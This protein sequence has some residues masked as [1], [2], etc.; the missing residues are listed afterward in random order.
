MKSAFFLLLLL[1]PFKG[2]TQIVSIDHILAKD[3]EK[4]YKGFIDLDHLAFYQTPLKLRFDN[5]KPEDISVLKKLR[6]KTIYKAELYYTSY[7][8]SAGF[9]QEDLNRKRL[10]ELKKVLPPLFENNAIEWKLIE[11][12]EDNEDK[13]KLLFHGFVFY[14]R[15]PYVITRNGKLTEITTK[16]EIDIIK[17]YLDDKLPLL[18]ESELDFR[19]E[20]V[21]D[22]TYESV[23]TGRKKKVRNYS[24]LFLPRS[25]RKRDK[26]ILYKK[27][28]IWNRKKDYTVEE[29]D[30][31][32]RQARVNCEKKKFVEPY[33]VLIKTV[34]DLPKFS[35]TKD[36][37]VLIALNK[38]RKNNTLIVE[39]VTGSMY[40]YLGQTF[41]WRRLNIAAGNNKNFAF[42]ND[43]DDKPDGPLGESYGVYSVPSDSIGGVE[44]TAFNTMKKGRGGATPENNIEA[45]VRGVKSSQIKVDNIILVADNYAPVRDISY[46]NS[47]LI[48]QIP[49]H[50]VVCG[51]NTGA[52]FYQYIDIARK[53]GGTIST[54]NEEINFSSRLAEGAVITVGGQK[55]KIVGGELILQ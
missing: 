7:R 29:A 48:L 6:A 50:V 24:S 13:A 47:L 39:D 8:S 33:F 25:K 2:I 4:R 46:L 10:L 26:G 34:D 37:V 28:S 53:T 23:P 36:S 3:T 31:Y 32:Q 35:L 54:L 22:T 19:Y 1:L 38:Y 12:V 15:E 41:K 45:M 52:V 18:Y 21:C 16:E 55:F 49:V 42:F 17:N 30:I 43:G 11:Q 14:S 40:P 51:S 20:T 5:S 9:S 27:K 44:N